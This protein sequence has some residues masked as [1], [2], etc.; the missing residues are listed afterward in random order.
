MIKSVLYE[1]E[2]LVPELFDM[3]RSTVFRVWDKPT[4][5]SDFVLR[6]SLANG[7]AK[8]REYPHLYISTGDAALDAE[9]AQ[10]REAVG[11]LDFFCLNDTLDDA[12]ISDPRLLQVAQTLAQMFPVASSFEY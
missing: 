6:W 7:R 5:V 9:L 12:P 3:V 1:L 10:L 8:L 4:I 11:L 2:A